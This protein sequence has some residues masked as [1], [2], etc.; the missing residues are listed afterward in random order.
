MTIRHS[1]SLIRKTKS[2]AA[3]VGSSSTHVARS[4][5][6]HPTCLL[7][8]RT[9]VMSFTDGATAV[10]SASYSRCHVSGRRQFVKFGEDVY[11]PASSFFFK[12]ARRLIPCFPCYPSAS[13][14]ASVWPRRHTRRWLCKRFQTRRTSSP[15][16]QCQTH[17][18]N[19]RSGEV[20]SG[21]ALP[22]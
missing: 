11:L 21:D 5:P 12:E 10:A 15:S 4:L 8:K 13:A 1:L 17:R 3:V 18:G 19:P 22:W 16:S 14:G 7:P 9:C 6:I 2:P 20:K